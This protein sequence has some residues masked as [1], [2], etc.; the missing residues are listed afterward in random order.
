MVDDISPV[1]R[2]ALDAAILAHV[3]DKLHP[4]REEGHHPTRVDISGD[5]RAVIYC[6]CGGVESM[7][8]WE[9]CMVKIMRQAVEDVTVTSFPK[10]P[11][12]CISRHTHR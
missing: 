5:Q 4:V 12:D 2:H 7:I 8:R 3:Y 9:T 1:M 10:T 6:S 11:E